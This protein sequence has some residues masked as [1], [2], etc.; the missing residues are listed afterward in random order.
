[1]VE[2]SSSL[3]AYT[4]FPVLRF[5]S[6]SADEYIFLNSAI[7]IKTIESLQTQGR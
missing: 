6:A 4:P 1:M 2:A 5:I 3:N 7:I